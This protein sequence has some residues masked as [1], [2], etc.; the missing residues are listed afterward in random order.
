MG[1]VYYRDAVGALVVFDVS[2]SQTFEAVKK[3][4]QDIDSKVFLPD[5]SPIPCVLLAN[6]SDLPHTI[7]AEQMNKYCADNGF[8]KW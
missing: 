2:R 1:K 5:Q 7:Q 4:K 8:I 6:K 3:W